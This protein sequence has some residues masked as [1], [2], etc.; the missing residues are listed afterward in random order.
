[1]GPTDYSPLRDASDIAAVS[2]ES[3]NPLG[4][5]LDVMRTLVPT[6]LK[7]LYEINTNKNFA[8]IPIMPEQNPFGAPKPDSQRYFRSAPTWAVEAA[9]LMF[10][11]TGGSQLDQ[12]NID[13]SPETLDHVVD[14]LTGASGAFWSRTYGAIEGVI[15][16]E[17]DEL[18]WNDVPFARKLIEGK[19]L[20]W[21]QSRYYDIR[22]AGQIA[23]QEI[24]GLTGAERADY[25]KRY[26]AELTAHKLTSQYDKTLKELRSQRRSIE[27][28]RALSDDERK[29]RL[30]LIEQRM[31]TIYQR[32]LSR[33]SRAVQAQQ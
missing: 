22:E 23:A 14:F 15:K 6:L 31:T 32:A 19:N 26:Q 28:A 3:F 20:Y 2:V 10:E 7:P 11:Q 27:N 1:M 25:A 8:D 9:D 21:R 16:G 24:K 30:D 29:R 17:A 12:F 5:E 13:V 33:Y 4:G 18:E